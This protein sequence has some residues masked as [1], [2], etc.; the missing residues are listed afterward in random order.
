MTDAHALLADRIRRDG[1]ATAYVC[2][3]FRCESP[4]QDPEGL[5]ALL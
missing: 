3:D 5:R 1:R 2:H 4:V